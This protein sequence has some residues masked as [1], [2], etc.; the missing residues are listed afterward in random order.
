MTKRALNFFSAA[1]C[2]ALVVNILCIVAAIRDIGKDPPALTLFVVLLNGGSLVFAAKAFFDE[3]CRVP[4]EE[5][6]VVLEVVRD[7]ES[8]IDKSINVRDGKA[9]YYRSLGDLP[10]WCRDKVALLDAAD[11]G[12]WTEIAGVGAKHKYDGKDR[13]HYKILAEK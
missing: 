9:T 3:I 13:L 12:D 5:C 6:K 7:E 4:Y 1:Y 2:V 10:L 8:T 11:N